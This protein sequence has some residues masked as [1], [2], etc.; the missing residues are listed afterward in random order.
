VKRAFDILASLALLTLAFP[1]CAA[2]ALA[3]K[4]TSR[5]PVLF[6]HIRCGRGGRDFRCLKFRTMVEDAEKWLERDPALLE[7]YRENGFKLPLKKDPRVTRVGK[8][9]RF[10]HLDELPQLLNVLGGNMSLVGPRPIIEEELDWYGD[11]VDDLLSVRPGVFGPWTAQGR[12]R[13]GYPERAGIEV[14]Y[15]ENGT[16]LGDVRILLQHFPILLSGQRDEV[17]ERVP[18]G[19]LPASRVA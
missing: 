5:G 1:L 19:A 8:V 4:L 18:A 17:E 6:G 16:L 15:V 7:A 3:V 14:G 11:R 12:R 13:V 2:V 10:T 9:L